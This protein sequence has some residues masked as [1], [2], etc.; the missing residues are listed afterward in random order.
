MQEVGIKSILGYSQGSPYQ[1][2]PFIDIFTPGGL[3]DMSNTPK[4]LVGID[5]KGNKK[6]MKAFSKNPYQF[7]GDVVREIPM[8]RGGS[9]NDLFSYLFD[10]DEDNQSTPSDVPTAPSTDELDAREEELNR[11]EAA[12]QNQQQYDLAMQIANEEFSPNNPY[13]RQ[14]RRGSQQQPEL[15]EDGNPISYP[16]GTLQGGVNP[17]VIQNQNDLMQKYKLGNLGIWGDAKH[18]QR[19][20]D[21]NT[22][23]AQDFTFD[24]HQ[25]A[26]Q[27]IAEL[28]S[29][30]KKRNVKYIVYN[31][32]IWNPSISPDWRPYDGP[33]PHK[34]HFHVSYNR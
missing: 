9:L 19:K 28:M 32:R 25:T 22:G 30:Y 12:L 17:Y 8:Q 27:A 4:D 31:G 18:Q 34:T 24:S 2:D 13:I 7:E 10:D 29:D 5:N 6:K 16:A 21:H 15:D 1:N 20:S 26:D 23:D 11:R 33:N 3:I 14:Q